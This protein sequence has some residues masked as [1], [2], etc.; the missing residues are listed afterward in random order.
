MKR[1]LSLLLSLMMI[2]T[3]VLGDISLAIAEDM[4]TEAVSASVEAEVPLSTDAGESGLIVEIEEIEVFD[5]P[6]QAYVEEIPETEMPDPEDVFAVPEESGEAAGSEAEEIPEQVASESEADEILPVSEN[7]GFSFGYV[8]ALDADVCILEAADSNAKTIAIIGK[9]EVVLCIECSGAFALVSFNTERGVVTGYAAAQALMPLVEDE[10]SAFMDEAAGYETVVLYNEDIDHPLSYIACEFADDA[11]QPETTDS[12]VEAESDASDLENVAGNASDMSADQDQADAAAGDVSFAEGEAGEETGEVS[13]ADDEAVEETGDVSSVDGEAGEETGEVS[14]VDGEAGEEMS[15]VSSVVGE[16]GEEMSGVS[17]VAGE[18]GEE[19]SGVSSVD[20]EAGEE[21]GD[22]SSVDGEGG[23]ETGDVSSADGEGGEEAGDV[24]AVEVEDV[25]DASEV[26]AVDGETPIDGENTIENTAEFSAALPEVYEEGQQESTQV[27]QDAS[28]IP[29]KASLAVMESFTL[30]VVDENGSI[31]ESGVVF[32]STD[33]NIASV[34][35]AGIVTANAVGS[36]TIT[37][38]VNGKALACAVNVTEAPASI[39]MS[40]SLSMFEGQTQQLTV[41]FEPETSA[42]VLSFESGNTGVAEVDENGLVT[43][44]SPGKAVISAKTRSG[45]IAECEVTVNAVPSKINLSSEELSMSVKMKATL[46][47]VILDNDGEEMDVDYI[48]TYIPEDPEKPAIE[49]NEKTGEIVA[50]NAGRASISVTAMN[51]FGILCGDDGEPLEVVCEITVAAAPAKVK[52]NASKG[53]IGLKEYFNGLVATA[54]DADG[55][56]VPATFTYKSSN[57]SYVTVDADGEIYGKKVG[58]AYVYAYA[59][60]GKYARCKVTV[61]KAPSSVTV[62]PASLTLSAGGMVYDA[63]KPSVNSG[64]A[65]RSYTYSGYDENIISVSESG[66]VT[67]K[68]AGSTSITVTSYNGKSKSVPVSVLNPPSEVFFTEDALTIG[69]GEVSTVSAWNRNVDGES[70]PASYTYSVAEEDG[71]ILSVD[72]VTGKIEGLATGKATV[73]VST[74]NGVTTGKFN[75]EIVTTACEVTVLDAPTDL[76]FAVSSRNV[77]YKEKYYNVMDHLRLVMPDGETQ[78]TIQEAEEKEL[79]HASYTFK[80]SNKSY[81]TVDANGVITG[82]KA[83]KSAYVTVTA[84]NGESARIKIA[85]KKAPTKVTV[86]PTTLKIGANGMQHQ[87]TA[88]VNSGAYTNTYTYTSSNTDAVKVDGNG[89]LTS[90][91]PG[92]A[93]ITVKSYNGKKATCKVTVYGEPDQITLS[94][95]ARTLGAGSSFT[96]KA[97]ATD[98]QGN[99]TYANYTYSVQQDSDIISVDASGKI[100]ALNQGSA[101]VT[102]RTHNGVSGRETENGSWE[103][104]K[105]VVRVVA[106]PVALELSTTGITIGYKETFTGIPG[107]VTL[108]AP[109]GEDECMANLSYKTSRKS[110][111]TVNAATGAVYGKK[112]GYSYITITPDNGAAPVKVKVTVKKTPTKA[113]LNATQLTLSEGGQIYQLKATVNSGAACSTYTWTSSDT[114]VVTVSSSG[115]VTTVGPGTATITAAPYKGTKATC[116]VTVLEAPAQVFLP[117]TITVA[118]GQ[119]AKIEAGVCG[120]EGTVSTADYTFSTNDSR[121]SV[122]AVTGEVRGL[123]LTGDDYAE[124]TVRTHNGVTTHYDENGVAVPT[125]CRVKVIEA[126][127]AVELSMTGATIGVGQTVYLAP[128]M[129]TSDGETINGGDFTYK[130]TSGSSYVSVNAEGAVKGKKAGTAY[131]TA[132]SADGTTSESCKIVVKKAPVSVSMTPATATMG[133]G[134]KN[135]FKVKLSSGSA[136]SYAFTSSNTKVAVV[137]SD[138]TVTAVGVG[139]ATITVKT[140]NGKKDTSKITVKEGPEFLDFNSDYIELFDETTGTYKLVYFEHMMPG[141]TFKLTYKPEAYTVGNAVNFVSEDPSIASVAEDGTVTAVSE[142]CTAILVESSSGTLE[143]CFIVVESSETPFEFID[144]DGK[145]DLALGESIP[146]PEVSNASD[147]YNLFIEYSMAGACAEIYIEEDGTYWLRAVAPGSGVLYARSVTFKE[148]MLTVNVSNAPEDVQ[149]EAPDVVLVGDTADVNVV[150]KNMGSYELSV[151]DEALA[152]ITSEGKLKAIKVGE[153]VLTATM[154]NGTA[155]SKTVLLRNAPDYVELGN[156]NADIPIGD[157]L[158]LEPVID[159]NAHAEY[160]FVS[161]D[162][163]VAE[164]SETGLITAKAPGSAR[165]TV[166]TQ[167]PNVFAVCDVTVTA[168]GEELPLAFNPESLRMK[169]GGE[170]GTVAVELQEGQTLVSV[171]CDNEALFESFAVSDT[172]ITIGKPVASGKATITAATASGASAECVVTVVEAPESIGVTVVDIVLAEGEKAQAGIFFAPENAWGEITAES[173]D[174]AVATADENGVITAIAPGEAQISFRT[175]GVD[176]A[177]VVNVKVVYAPETIYLNVESVDLIEGASLKLDAPELLSTQG[178]SGGSYT[179]TVGDTAVAD[180]A[181]DGNLTAVAVGSTA[182][183]IRA[184]N[185]VSA[186]VPVKVWPAA[187]EIAFAEESLLLAM[188]ESYAPVVL[189]EDGA[190]V[191]AAITSDNTGVVNVENGVLVGVS[192]GTAEITATY[193]EL[194]ARMAVQVCKVTESVVLNAEDLI[195]GVKEQFTVKATLDDGAASA[196]LEILSSDPTVVSVSRDGLVTALRPGTATITARAFGGASDLI[197]V[198]VLAAPTGVALMP[199]V[200]DGNVLEKG[201]QLEWRFDSEDQGGSIRFE[202]DDES[203]ASVDENGWVTFHKVGWTTVGIVTYNGY[204]DTVDVTVHRVPEKVEF[205]CT[206]IVIQKGDAVSNPVRMTDG[207]YADY[208]IVSDDENVVSVDSDGN[209]IAV[210]AGQAIVSLTTSCGLT[211]QCTVTVVDKLEG[212]K[213]S[214]ETLGLALGEEKSLSV[215]FADKDAVANVRFVSSNPSIASVDEWT[216][217]VKGLK[218][219]SC[220]IYVQ[221][222]DGSNSDSCKVTVNGP[223][224]RMFMAYEYFSTEFKHNLAFSQNNV[225]S[226]KAAFSN[227]SINGVKYD[228]HTMK[229]PSKNSLLSGMASYFADSNESDV[230]VIYLCSHGHANINGTSVGGVSQYGLSLQGYNTSYDLDSPYYYITA[231]ELYACISQIKGKVVLILDSCNSGQFI[232]NMKSRLDME[233]NNRIAVLTA[234]Q[235]GTNASYYDVTSTTKAV[236]FFT[237]FLLYGIGYDEKKDKLDYRLRADSNESGVVSLKEFFNY[238]KTATSAYVSKSSTYKASWFHGSSYQVPQSYIKGDMGDLIIYAPK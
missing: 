134:Q 232:T 21:A 56:E 16:A 227:S 39:S 186:Y 61:K 109:E 169:V 185:G 46:S 225:N 159:V 233:E 124:I 228:I 146:L 216:G 8:K 50:K 174:S 64:A 5:T 138:G 165:I 189:S 105:C 112:A 6:E 4:E 18:A 196:G 34:S 47:A 224:Y 123:Q 9:G 201:V 63:L 78:I 80:S 153:I 49:V 229:N 214:D 35:E 117:E 95:T 53:S 131:V 181:A 67:T 115:L 205:A 116:T 51:G 215:S 40:E 182:V 3:T 231:T 111:V 192:A 162:S 163:E 28:L 175:E 25:D 97:T 96:L 38:L 143:M 135:K 69:V 62:K 108:V 190:V 29:E 183:K 59:H 148:A 218:T 184:Y 52:L 66:V 204:T 167:V 142:G 145:I 147:M 222:L 172:V 150:F 208:E 87:L 72:P 17:S 79:Y 92:T 132:V 10:I 55:N 89:L 130:V 223:R 73:L 187:Q 36:C 22:V 27:P 156:V 57:K 31:V 139:T 194:T 77:G 2:F 164:V 121:I 129:K 88:K 106:A 173:T 102:V 100:T 234:V 141:T 7:S 14:S 65:C 152:V 202:S 178:V 149:I 43:A 99:S 226:M 128:V 210:G 212:M 76:A 12:E 54:Y 140:Y 198:V 203:I 166:R 119:R 217:V 15:G 23:E 207:S 179:W 1:W 90:V 238:G 211:A 113:K 155:V 221:T 41:E 74:H 30:K 71:H 58:S 60:T 13:S 199:A 91:N 98:A 45:C 103:E 114:S 154:Q 104:S 137:E 85:V 33:A 126:P 213:I 133:V 230:N 235:G 75:D 20:G 197:D 195:L 84:H 24:P 236:D 48:F 220:T 176:D 161:S 171:V 168:A 93:T 19:M 188:G 70:A 206:E 200:I 158:Q 11:E 219:G 107:L 44:K 82:K 160:T 157:T 32:A 42:S 177:A 101:V 193:G 136:G 237:Y 120:I 180:I 127:A 68:N 122:D 110:Y 191:N 83:G 81:V 26:P 125:V 94:E 118:Q 151:D 209:F 86:S 144:E 37:A 170:G